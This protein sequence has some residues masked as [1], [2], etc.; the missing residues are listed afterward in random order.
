MTPTEIC[1]LLQPLNLIQKRNGKLRLD[2]FAQTPQSWLGRWKILAEVCT[3]SLFP[4]TRRLCN[5]M[6]KTDV[7]ELFLI[8]NTVFLLR[9]AKNNDF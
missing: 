6:V 7:F 2:R 5:V 4:C 9:F 3:I 1:K 8:L